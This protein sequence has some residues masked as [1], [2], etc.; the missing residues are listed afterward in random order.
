MITQV[1]HLDSLLKLK[2]ERINEL[3]SQLERK[4]TWRK[5]VEVLTNNITMDSD[6]SSSC[7]NLKQDCI[8]LPVKTN[9]VKIV[10]SK[11]KID[12]SK[13]PVAKDSF[14]TISIPSL[15]DVISLETN[16]TIDRIKSD[17]FKEIEMDDELSDKMDCYQEIFEDFKDSVTRQDALTSI[18]ET[19]QTEID[20]SFKPIEYQDGLTSMVK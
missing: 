15:T 3:Q 9:S 2:E 18:Q 5:E 11:T 4:Q 17:V 20:M 16:D 1:D 7:L 12:D 10:G 13:I 19:I 6:N 14:K 8:I